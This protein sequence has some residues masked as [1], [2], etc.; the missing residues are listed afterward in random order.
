VQTV[1]ETVDVPICIDSANPE[2]LKAA[3]KLCKGKPIINSVSGEERSLQ[4]VLPLVK[5]YGAAVIGLT[6]DDDGI[7]KDA[8]KRV[9]IATKIVERAEKLG[10]PREDVLID[11]LALAAGAEPRSVLII[12]DTV[13]EVKSKLGLNMT[14]GASNISYGLPDRHL[15]NLSLIPIVI[16]AGINCPVV[17]AARVRPTILATDLLLARDL[18][19]RRYIEAYRKR[20]ALIDQSASAPT[21]PANKPG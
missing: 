2:A 6:Q 3:L 20:Q 9:A 16:A 10:I 15:I 13:C 5:E 14:L 21:P 8:A 12:L 7:P 18:R 17:D 4:R 1:L 11:C 19:A